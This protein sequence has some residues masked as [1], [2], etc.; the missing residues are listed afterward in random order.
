MYKLEE[1]NNSKV[2]ELK[3]I[4]KKLNI[5]NYE[6]LKKLDLAYAILDHQAEQNEVT[7]KPTKAS[8]NPIAKSSAKPSAKPS[9]K[10]NDKAPIKKEN[11]KLE[12]KEVKITS[13]HN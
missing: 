5:S 2:T 11:S 7:K 1:L 10:A 4:A 9:A 12:S 13:K 3:E 8:A 6:K